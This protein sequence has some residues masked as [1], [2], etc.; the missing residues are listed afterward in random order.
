M[1]APNV[2]TLL[3]PQQ[4]QFVSA[5]A[6]TT[7]LSPQVAGAW[8]RNEEPKLATNTD[9]AGHG[10]Y[11]FL[12]I[13]ITGSKNYGNTLPQWSDPTQAGTFAGKWATGQASIPGFGTSSKGIQSI[14]QTRGQSAQSQINAIQNSGWAAGGETALPSLYQQFS[15]VSLPAATQ[16]TNLAK[17]IDS[18]GSVSPSKGLVAS[19]N[20]NPP[21]STPAQGGS[22]LD[23][24]TAKMSTTPGQPASTLTSFLNKSG[25]PYQNSSALLGY[26][27]Q[28]EGTLT[29]TPASPTA[30]PITVQASPGTKATST[31][32]AAIDLAKKYLGTAYVFGGADPNTGFDCS[33]LVQYTLGKQGIN[34]PRTSQEQWQA[35]KPVTKENLRP[36]DVVFFVG[37][38]G[39]PTSPGHE[40]MYLGNGQYIESPHTGDV[41]KIADL[42]QAKGFVGARS[43]I[44]G[45]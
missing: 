21:V 43:F 23:Y 45:T 12:N 10:A 31:A 15:G 30:T 6:K 44:P 11:N 37:S 20:S 34:V 8:V 38:D 29:S 13:G 18:K 7:G 33:G 35:G 4:Q 27:Q 1:A 14:F 32:V 5:F 36:G 2:N 39:T 28:G 3:S 26:I 19:P 40:G 41:V 17:S 9:P 16:Q 24:L 25:V 22:F 42:S